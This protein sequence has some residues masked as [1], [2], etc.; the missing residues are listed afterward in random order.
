TLNAPVLGIGEMVIDDSNGN[1]NGVLDP[2]ESVT[3]T[4]PVSNDGQAESPDATATLFC[5]TNGIT[6]GTGT[7]NLGPLGIESVVDAVYTVSADM[8]IPFGTPII[9]NF[10]VVAG[11][12]EIAEDFPTQVGIHQ[13]DFENGFSQYPWEFQGYTISWPNVNPIEDFTIVSPID[14]I[15][16]SIDTTEFYSGAASAKSYPITHNQASFMSISL[17][18]TM[19][20]E[21]SFWYKVACEYSPSQ[22]YFYDGLFFM[23]D[24][25]TAGQFQPDANGQSPWTFASYPVETGIH[26]F[27]WVYVKDGSDG[28]TMI[29]D[30][31]AWV[32]L[33]TFP[34]ITP[35]PTGTIAGA[36]SVIPAANLEEVEINVGSTIINPD[37]SGQ[38]SLDVPVGTY[39]VIASLDGYETITIADVE[40]LEGQVTPIS[41]VLYYLQAPENLVAVNIDEIVNLTWEHNQP[42]ANSGRKREYSNREFQN[43]NIYRS[44]DA[45]FYELLAST[46][47]LFYEDILE[48]AGEYSYYMTAVYD[49][50]NESEASNTETVIWDGTGSDDPL[51]P[52][53]N[54]LYQNS[55]NPFNPETKISFD[56]KEEWQVNLEIYNMKGQKVRT[57]ISAQLSTGQHSVIWNGKDDA[58]K[59]VSS[60]IYFYKIKAGEFQQTRKMLL[61]K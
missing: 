53:V 36:V 58:G 24:G 2:G 30:D 56:L 45:S 16:W 48:T 40:V 39:N 12:Y 5:A 31:C 59:P 14:N 46:D 3:I 42:A 22:T 50:G 18:V 17:D 61:M 34:S 43:F 29:Q 51:I 19:D 13:E 25:V 6:I 55:P 47:D 54:A 7:I 11:E 57:L 37:A 44:V 35:L 21:I 28:T 9:L 60:G 38:F 33:V 20:G 15:D 49:Q 32:D 10:N 23:I 4:I 52:L 26:T 27:D 41:F 8:S 1:D